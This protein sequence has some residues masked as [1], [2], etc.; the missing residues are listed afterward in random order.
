VRPSTV[1]VLGLLAPMPVIAQASALPQAYSFVELNSMIAPDMTIKAY[2][3]GSRE[4]LLQTRPVSPGSPKGYRGGLYYDFQAHF[5][6]VWDATAPAMFDVVSGS[7]EMM[8]DA[9]P[10]MKKPGMPELQIT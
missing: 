6:Y 7:A 10:E 1:I 3:D 8:K 9:A 4:I 2:R 5:M